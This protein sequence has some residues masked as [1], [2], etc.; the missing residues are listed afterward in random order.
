ML[1]RKTVNI[2]CD[3]CNEIT[4]T[5]KS[6]KLSE[7]PKVLSINSGV[8]S[9]ND[10]KLLDKIMS[11]MTNKPSRSGVKRKSSDNASSQKN[12]TQSSSDLMKPAPW[13]PMKFTVEI[14]DELETVEVN[15]DN[16]KAHLE[17][18][19]KPE[20]LMNKKLKSYLL[21][22]VL[23]LIENEKEKHLVSLVYVGKLQHS[24]KSLDCP[25]NGQWYIFNDFR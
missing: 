5:L 6:L 22:S 19:K 24:L 11:K 23:C 20:K 18:F 2:H 4:R 1:S 12:I 9:E 8:Q 17:L 13:F 10:M 15:V 14:F 25:G 3:H 21:S 16:R 7:L